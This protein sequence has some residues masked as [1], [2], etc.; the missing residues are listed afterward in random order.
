MAS[1]QAAAVHNTCSTWAGHS[2]SHSP[3]ER[4]AAAC[5]GNEQWQRIQCDAQPSADS[6]RFSESFEAAH[7]NHGFSG[8]LA[9]S[10]GIT[11]APLRIDSQ[12]KYGAHLLQL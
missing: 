9:Q 8:A 2:K 7:S 6:L 1:K 5:T 11:R 12:A 3:V 4:L 10:L